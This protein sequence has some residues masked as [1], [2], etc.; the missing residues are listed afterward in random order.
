M[1]YKD[2]PED[3]ENKE[4]LEKIKKNK[5]KKEI[6]KITKMFSEIDIKIKNSVRSLIENA[7]FMS[8]TLQDLQDS[9]NKNGV[10]EEY[11]NGATQFGIKKS[12]EVEI[13]NSMIKNYSSV[14]KQLTDLLPKEGPKVVDDG[15]D[16]FVNSRDK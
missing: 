6:T 14:I 10:T 12:S 9:I 7:A 2:M 15:F 13:Y 11:R 8:V 5:I 4:Q 16:D 1:S 3:A